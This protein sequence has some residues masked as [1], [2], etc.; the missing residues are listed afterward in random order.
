MSKVDKD[1]LIFL[2]CLLFLIAL[3]VSIVT[4]LRFYIERDK[5]EALNQHT[6]MEIIYDPVVGCLTKLHDGTYVPFDQVKFT[7]E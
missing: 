2:T 6:K 5:C 1:A 7:K 4:G 3:A